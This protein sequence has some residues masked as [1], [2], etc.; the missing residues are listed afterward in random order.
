MSVCNE[1]NVCVHVSC[2]DS[3]KG[4]CS[5]PTGF[6]RHFRD[7][8]SKLQAPVNSEDQSS[9]STFLEGWIKLLR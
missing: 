1:C 3:L 2:A 6:V 5:L 4:T 9:S 8:L 7:S